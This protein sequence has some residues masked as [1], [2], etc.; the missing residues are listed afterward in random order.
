M[1]IKSLAFLPILTLSLHAAETLPETLS[2]TKREY[3]RVEEDDKAARL[4]TSIVTMEK[5][6]KRVDLIG[7]IHIADKAYYSKLNERF[8]QYD[9]LLFEM[10][11]GEKL[12]QGE[13]DDAPKATDAETEIEEREE[14]NNLSGLKD[15]YS[16]V[17]KFLQLSGQ[18]ETIDYKAKNF[19][20]ADLTLK[21]FNQKQKERN[22]SLLGLALK[23]NT[24]DAKAK[25][26]DPARLM[27]AMFS[28][29]S[30][31]MKLELIH[32]LGQ[33]DDQVSMFAG[34][35]VIVTD[36]N[37]KCLEVMEKQLAAGQKKL[38]IF[39]GSAHFP[40][41]EKT[42]IKQGW[43]RS[44]EEWLTAWDIPKTPAK[45]KTPAAPTNKNNEQI[46][47]KKKAA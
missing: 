43:K 31:R 40:D 15:I 6:G 4:Q 7:A 12:L 20:H 14:P 9:R 34:E 30:N 10:V 41:M 47:P 5:D 11:G 42:L 22:E 45:A 33:G 21:E 27:A 28:G 35:T 25:Q 32:T 39:Y 37:A 19:V 29:N 1:S 46:D 36:R 26:P 8:S 16:M 17:A 44:C 23:A 18:S 24:Q 38:G 2:E 3:I 13:N